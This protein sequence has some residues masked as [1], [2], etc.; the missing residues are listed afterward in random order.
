MDVA[1][2]PSVRSQKL[3]KLLPAPNGSL[4]ASTATLVGDVR[5]GMNSSVWY[6]AVLRGMHGSLIC[7]HCDV[8]L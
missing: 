5:V 6:G 8:Q 2:Q 7:T 3:G 4:V 1:V